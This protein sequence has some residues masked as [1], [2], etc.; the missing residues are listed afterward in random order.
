MVG[1]GTVFRG[2]RPRVG[3]F[4]PFFFPVVYFTDGSFNIPPMFCW[5][6]LNFQSG[7]NEKPS[8]NLKAECLGQKLSQK[9]TLWSFY[10]HVP[11]W[12]M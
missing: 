3:I 12:Q 8:S 5:K 10:L 2:G 4:I 1:V 6:P 7:G 11:S 9:M